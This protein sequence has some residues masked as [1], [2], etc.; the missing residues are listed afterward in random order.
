MILVVLI[1]GIAAV[2]LMAAVA[3]I[4]LGFRGGD[5]PGD[6]MLLSVTVQADLSVTA[7]IE[8]P[9]EEAVLVGICLR[10]SG[11]RM[12]LE[13][14]LYVRILSRRPRVRITRDVLPDD[15]VATGVVEPETVSAF[16]VPAE[17]ASGRRTELVAV[18]A[19]Q[20][21][22]RAIHRLIA[23]P[24]VCGWRTRRAEVIRS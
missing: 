22:L 13:G 24:P 14:R 19:Q 3:L 7:I 8:N 4:P 21:R 20:D 15:T 12:R 6:V 11:L 5:K 9:A 17:R 2:V 16:T 1:G 10:P 23:L 18:V